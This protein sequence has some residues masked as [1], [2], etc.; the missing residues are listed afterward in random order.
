[1]IGLGLTLRSL[2][3]FD[4]R[5]LECFQSMKN[6][7]GVAQLVDESLLEF[8]RVRICGRWQQR[9]SHDIA[10]SPASEVVVLIDMREMQ[11]LRGD[12]EF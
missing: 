8:G 9:S 11:P 4:L 6:F 7:L 10:Q 12:D 1:M 2:L 5:V 3:P